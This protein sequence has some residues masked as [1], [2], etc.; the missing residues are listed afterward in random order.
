MGRTGSPLELSTALTLAGFAR[1]AAEPGPV[2]GSGS[3][4]AALGALG[5]G[6]ASMAL[7]ATAGESTT[8][9]QDDAQGA[10][11]AQDHAQGAAATMEALL[12]RVDADATAY[13]RYLEARAGHGDLAEA[14]AGSIAVPREVAEQALAALE[15][16]ERGLGSV[17]PRL[18]SEAFTASRAL[19]AAVESAC[20]TAGSNLPALD[21]PAERERVRTTLEALRARAR[22]CGARLEAA[23][24]DPPRAS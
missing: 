15:R 6:L 17:R 9:R 22:A 18:R 4:A 8:T 11:G 5:A 7:R 13:A 16:L 10:Q 12:A 1:K 2:P 3:V 20:H 23:L 21:D 24:S 19:L 14:V